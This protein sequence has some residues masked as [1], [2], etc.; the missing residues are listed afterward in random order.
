MLAPLLLAHLAAAAFWFGALWPLYAAAARGAAATRSGALIEQFSRL[1][2]RDRAAVL[3]A[4]L[5][6]AVVFVRSLAD[7]ATPYG[8]IVIAK[9]VGFGAA[10]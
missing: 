2:S 6:M 7:L 5:G 10:A 8:A 3:L 9:T 4:G 1:A